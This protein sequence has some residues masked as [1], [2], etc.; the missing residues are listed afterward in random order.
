M[1]IEVDNCDERQA[2]L[3]RMIAEFREAQT[4]RY[5]KQA[6]EKVTQSKLDANTKEP[7]TGSA[8]PR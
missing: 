8:V 2:R 1:T 3:D 5:M 7:L 6:G 4:L